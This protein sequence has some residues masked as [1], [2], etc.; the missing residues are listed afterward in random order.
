MPSR[1]DKEIIC[2]ELAIESTDKSVVPKISR[3][4]SY[5]VI[6]RDSA[7]TSK[8]YSKAAKWELEV[9]HPREVERKAMEMYTEMPSPEG[10]EFR[11]MM[12]KDVCFFM[13]LALVIVGCGERLGYP[14]TDPIFGREQKKEDMRKWIVVIFYV[15]NQIPLLVLR[16]LMEQKI[17]KEVIATA[18]LDRPPSGLCE[19]VL[20]DVL[21]LPSLGRNLQ[22]CTLVERVMGRGPRGND[23]EK[24]QQQPNLYHDL[25]YGFRNLLIGG[26]ST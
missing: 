12:I 18:R 11:W 15:G 10:P 3:I 7:G 20:Y 19:K 24:Q 17:F 16:V 13:Q 4:L 14:E 9:M 1:K 5:K 25:L 21:I 6:V 22:G 26:P 2:N 8:S 23:I